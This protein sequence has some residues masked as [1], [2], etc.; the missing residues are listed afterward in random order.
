MT[1]YWI[2]HVTITDSQAYAGYREQAA[3][4][5]AR[6]GAEFLARGGAAETFEGPA[7]QR[8]VVIRFPDL[9]SARACYDSPE[10]REARRRREG[11]AVTHL[12]IVEGL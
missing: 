8:H 3:I 5:F 4:A 2:A 10:Y 1:A 9:A 12:V 6:Y 7:L 11:A